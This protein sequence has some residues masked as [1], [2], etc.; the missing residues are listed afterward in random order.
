MKV[1]NYFFAVVFVLI[2]GSVAHG[3]D[4]EHVSIV[5]TLADDL[6]VSEVVTIQVSNNTLPLLSM[7]LPKGAFNVMVNNV[8]TGGSESV[9]ITLDCTACTRTIK[10]SLKNSAQALPADAYT[11]Q[12][13]LHLPITPRTLDYKVSLP[14]GYVVSGQSNT[15]EY[16]VVPATATIESDGRSI[17]VHW[18]ESNPEMPKIYSIRYEGHER[19]ETIVQEI[20]NELS[21]KYVWLFLVLA[22]AVGLGVGLLL[23]RKF[24]PIVT[25][26]SSLLNSDEKAIIRLLQSENAQKQKELARKLNWSKSKTSSVCTN[27]VQKGIISRQK[28][29]RNYTI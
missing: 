11:Y 10:Y 4:L 27:L 5:D 19:Q 28:L 3:Y 6:T 25:V 21:E 22:C 1:Q 26:P 2:S 9:N 7:Q 15:S 20:K 24:V 17:V 29:G 14:P 12:R 16:S 18:R 8:A 23:R 13:V